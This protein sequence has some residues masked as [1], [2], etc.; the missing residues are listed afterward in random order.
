VRLFMMELPDEN[1]ISSPQLHPPLIPNTVYFNANRGLGYHN[2]SIEH[3]LINTVSKSTTSGF[4]SME[5][6]REVEKNWV[7]FQ[8]ANNK[9]KIIYNWLPLVIGDI[10][11]DKTA[12]ST[13]NMNPMIFEKSHTIDTPFFFKHLRGSTNGIRIPS[14]NEIWFICHTVSYEDRRYY[15]HLFVVLDA[16]TY[17]VKKYTPFFTFEKEKVEY[18]L[19]FV[20]FEMTDEIM[21]GYS[22]MD[23][24]TK[25]MMIDKLVIDN[26]LIT[27]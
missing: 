5:G 20:Y 18:T 3:G 27:L 17:E 11:T 22:L 1:T 24:K 19:G 26:M 13:T 16:T 15:Y 14:N 6:Q 7:L 25:Y 10:E 4:I 23:C 2:I 9:M 21:I 12:V 8:D